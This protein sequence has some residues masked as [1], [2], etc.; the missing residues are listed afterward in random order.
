M[1][2][3][4]GYV[5]ELHD[6]D[7]RCPLC[8]CGS[9]PSGHGTLAGTNVCPCGCGAPPSAHLV[10]NEDGLRVCGLCAAGV[11]HACWARSGS[12]FCH[13][14]VGSGGKWLLL[15]Q[16]KFREPPPPAPL[17]EW[18]GLLVPMTDAELDAAVVQAVPEAVIVDVL[19]QVPARPPAGPVE[20]A[21]GAGNRQATKFGRL[22]R[23]RGG[24]AEA[25]YW[26]AAD[27]TEGCA[28]RIALGAGRAVATYERPSGHV[29]AAAGWKAGVAYVWQD[30]V[31]GTARR[32]THTE[33]EGFLT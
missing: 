6:A 4:C 2:C 22:V 8:A 7:G 33:L 17:R 27:G 28:V 12:G 1:I 3:V 25:R 14:R 15:R 19:P 13:G 18:F 26:R 24:E 9:P 10:P 21:G 20:I 11:H 30:G 31:P 5:R 23:E 16:G 32:I 29:G